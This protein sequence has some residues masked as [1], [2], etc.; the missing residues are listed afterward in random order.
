[1]L[2]ASKW[3]K[4]SFGD[5]PCGVLQKAAKA[6]G[7]NKVQKAVVQ[8]A[9][10]LGEAQTAEAKQEADDKWCDTDY[11]KVPCDVLK[12]AQKAG[13]LN[14][15]S[16]AQDEMTSLLE[17]S[18][19]GMPSGAETAFA[20]SDTNPTSNFPGPKYGLPGSAHVNVDSVTL[21]VPCLFALVAQ[22]T[23]RRDATQSILT[24]VVVHRLQG[25]PQMGS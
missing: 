6:G 9:V 2:Q 23:S 3:C 16:K 14:D 24:I 17:L 4:T 22:S 21:D 12:S 11:G 7:L 20:A 5:V 25:V 10:V 18:E 8:K 15:V 19:Q 1:M 13:L